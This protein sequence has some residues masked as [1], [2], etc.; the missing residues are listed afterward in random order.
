MPSIEMKVPSVGESILEVTV[1]E[2]QKKDGDFVEEAEV[3]CELESEKASF[4]IQA[5]HSGILKILAQEGDSLAI[6]AV[7]CEIDAS[8]KHD[9][10]TDSSSNGSSSVSSNISPG[11]PSPSTELASST[12]PA[13]PAINPNP[14]SYAKEHP[15]PSAEKILSEH[16]IDPKTVNGTGP[17]GRITKEDAQKSISKKAI[18][19]ESPSV[20]D[21]TSVMSSLRS[22][23]TPEPQAQFSRKTYGKRFSTLRKTIATRLLTAKNETAMLSTFNEV[24][25]KEIKNLRT[26]Y[27]DLYLK[28]Y[29]IKLGFMSFF[30]KACCLALKEFPT[31][32]AQ[33]KENELLY[34]EY[35]DI[36]IAVSTPKGL[37]TPIIRNAESLGFAEIEKEILRLSL[38]AKDGQ[39]QMEEMRGGTFTITN[40]GIFGSMLSTPILNPPQ[41]AI[42]GMHNIVERPV[43]RNGEIQVRPMMYVALS[44]DHRVI[45]GRESV[46]FLFRVKEFL[47]N[48]TRLL[49]E[50]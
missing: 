35:C 7:L 15:S 5:E 2:W 21:S 6:G 22:V 26:Q 24:D 10:P 13:V 49:L 43:V 28:R 12:V 40:G 4:S 3:L 37:V 34:H 45:D 41:S 31:V 23:D 44:Y 46:S 42:L 38:K 18:K 33:L 25:L 20:T 11:S 30:T 1:G 17:G 32:Q 50:I 48:P 9:Q 27:N 39:L 36:S 29:A 8:K 16:S 14:S 47:E 19:P